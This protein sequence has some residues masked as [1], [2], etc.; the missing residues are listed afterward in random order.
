MIQGVTPRRVR[1]WWATCHPLDFGGN[2]RNTVLVAGEGR[3]GTT[4]LADLIN[5]DQRYRDLFEPFHAWMVRDAEVLKGHWYQRPGDTPSPRFVEYVNRVLHGRIRHPWIDRFNR[6]PVSRRR[7]VKAIRANLFLGWLAERYSEVKILI[8]LRHPAEVAKSRMRLHE[9]WEWRPT[10]GEML[11]QPALREDLDG[12]QRNRLAQADS[13]FRN[14]VG[15]WCLA[16]WG[17]LFNVPEGRALV[18]RY[19]DLQQEPDCHLRRIFDYLGRPWDPGC[20]DAH[21]LSSRTAR[22]RTQYI[23]EEIKRSYWK[24]VATEDCEWTEQAMAEFDLDTFY[25]D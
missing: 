4:W 22:N 8:L 2:T 12:A 10:L 3:S 24:D 16:N 23:P 20:L 18:V 25:R 14:H 5:F 9:G 17:A 21:S 1:T 6:R 19:E 15:S 13:V 11:A 7:I